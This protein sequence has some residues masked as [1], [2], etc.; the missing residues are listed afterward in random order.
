MTGK[1]FLGK[2]RYFIFVLYKKILPLQPQRFI[3]LKMIKRETGVN[4][5]QSRCCIPSL[6][7]ANKKPLT[8]FREGV[9]IRTVS[10]KTCLAFRLFR[11]E[12]RRRGLK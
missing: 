3:C 5:V 10:Q 1:C 11:L 8:F 7:G 6:S 2:K 9:R 12:E 4:P